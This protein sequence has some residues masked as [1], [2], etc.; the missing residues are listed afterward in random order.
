M[1]NTTIDFNLYDRQI[2]TIG[3]EAVKLIASSEVTIIGLESGLATELGKNLAL[4]G[5]KNI[6]L[7][8]DGEITQ[9]DLENGYYYSNNDIS[10][11]RNEILKEKLQEL[12]SYVSINTIDDLNKSSEESVVIIINKSLEYIKN[13]NLNKRKMVV[14]FSKGVAGS[15]FVY[16]GE[17]HIITDITGENIE[18]V[19]IGS[20]SESGEVECAPNASHDYQTN[21]Y[22]KFINLEGVDVDFLNNEYQIEVINKRKFKLKNFEKVNNFIFKNGTSTHIKK[23]ITISHKSFEENLKDPSYNFSFDNSELIF[24]SFTKYFDNKINYSDDE[25]KLVKTFEYELI[26]VVSLIGSIGASEVIKLITH[27]CMPVSQV[28]CWYEPSLIPTKEPENKGNT[29]LGKM[30]GSDFEKRMKESSWF[31]VGSGAI[32]CELLKNLAI[33]KVSSDNEG[34]LHLTDPDN[35]ENSNL[36]RQF[37]FRKEHIKQSKSQTAASVISKMSPGINI[38]PYLEKVCRNNQSFSNSIM[39]KV[40][41]VLNA[42]DNVEARKYMDEQC[43]SNQ[44]PLF[45][46]GTTGTKGNTQPVIPYITQSYNDSADPPMEKD[47]P[48]C[49]LKTFPNNIQHTIPWARDIF[50]ELFERAF[51]NINK[52]LKDETVFNNDRIIDNIQAKQDIV[53]F[54]VE[55]NVKS[56]EDCVYEAIKLFYANYKNQIVQLLTTFPPD[57]KTEGDKLFWSNGKRMPAFFD[58]DINNDYHLDF[59][60]ATSHLFARCY[61]ILNEKDFTREQVKELVSKTNYNN[62]FSP[63]NSL[64]IAS[65]DEELKEK[66]INIIDKD[67]EVKLPSNKDYQNT[68]FIPQEFEKDDESNWHVAWITAASNLRALNYSIP[69]I[70]KQE[71]KGIAGRIIP[72]IATT[73][74]VVSGLIILE[75]IKYMLAKNNLLENKVENYR[76]TFVN[77]ADTTLVYSEPLPTKMLEIGGVK[78]SNWENFEYNKDTSLKEFKTYF[79]NKFKTTIDTIMFGVATL[80]ASY[81]ED[82]LDKSM[83]DLI[84][85]IDDSVDL[86]IDSVTILIMSSENIELPDV[87]FSVKNYSQPGIAGPVSQ[88]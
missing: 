53:K 21:D 65:N 29:V 83:S 58:L 9:D 42:L 35:I 1:S 40:D 15:I 10:K 81:H 88:P 34:T 48:I 2:R 85:E 4:F 72:A 16:A 44:K 37:L 74:S 38:V 84:K 31:V 41:G 67:S 45:E 6:N 19:E 61:N 23:S 32:G 55:M 36:N 50:V 69:P 17:N 56:F 13:I 22:I 63:D 73:T 62:D 46:S 27:K 47:I 80:Y 14:L 28:W 86:K 18:P 78:F 76:S 8:N 3:I 7:L 5:V 70:G 68:Q 12:N 52:W 66:K 43:F 77:L 51:N 39:K 26:P 24:N 82:D 49:T 33:L 60:E 25:S 54:L 20:I 11:S 57:T 59:I 87:H 30:F 75:M 64:K 71:T 79:E